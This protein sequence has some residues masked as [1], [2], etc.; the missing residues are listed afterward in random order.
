MLAERSSPLPKALASFDAWWTLAVVFLLYVFSYL[1]RFVITMVVTDVK[2]SLNISDLQMG[3]ILGPAFSICFSAFAIPFGWAS[4]RISRRWVIFGG[5]VIFGIATAVSGFAT[6]FLA[7][8]LARIFVGVGEASLSPAALSLIGAKFP[9][10]LMTTAISIYS[11]GPK[12]GSAAAFAIGGIAIA[13]AATMVNRHPELS[14]VEPWRVVFLLTGLPAILVGLLVFTFRETPRPAV[15]ASRQDSSAMSFLL[16]EWRLMLP[17][18]TGFSLVI[19]CG[20]SLIAWVPTY[21]ARRF[22]LDA[23]HYGAIL[24][25]ISMAGALTLVVKGG[26]MDWFYARGVKDIHLRFFTWILVAT[27][28]IVIGAFLVPTPGLFFALY[29]VV[30]IVTIPSIAYLSVAVQM[31]SPNAL[32]GRIAATAMI[33]VTLVGSLGPL[34]VGAITDHV[35]RDEARLGDSLALVLGTMIPSALLLLR[36][37]LKPLRAAVVAAEARLSAAGAATS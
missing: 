27:L 15:S 11:M 13:G 1:D 37:A 17:M 5:V 6:S 26:V 24:S 22:E 4:D 14:G 20:Q 28:P 10:N 30:G 34:I 19:I 31:V 2:R 12:V 25:V 8:L 18:L 33:P 9:R 35:F 21:I 23:L 16:K 7:L 29:A 36:I 32:R 3:L